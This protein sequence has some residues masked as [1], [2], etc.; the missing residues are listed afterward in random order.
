MC[1]K[2]TA[3][4]RSQDKYS[5]QLRLM[6]YWSLDMP[7]FSIH[8]CSSA[9]T[10]TDGIVTNLALYVGP[11]RSSSQYKPFTTDIQKYAITFR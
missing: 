1:T 3:L 5:T 4:G 2:N 11:W 10:S 7:V 6:P 8:T 9:L